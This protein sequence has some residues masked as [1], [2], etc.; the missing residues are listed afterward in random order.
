MSKDINVSKHA[1][2]RIKE[3]CGVGKS[4]A[5]RMANLAI[6]RGADRGRTKGPLRSWLDMKYAKQ[7]NGQIYVY[8]DKAYVI[9]EDNVLVTVLCIPNEFKK[10]L[11]KMIIQT[12]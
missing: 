2:K 11:K 6:E 1:K 10:N 8:G 3:R 4:S 9:S 7:K 12:A 5:D